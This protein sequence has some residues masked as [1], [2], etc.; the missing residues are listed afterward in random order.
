MHTFL[1]SDVSISVIS[2]TI[3]GFNDIHKLNASPFAEQILF[4]LTDEIAL[5]TLIHPKAQTGSSLAYHE[6]LMSIC[7]RFFL[8][9]LIFPNRDTRE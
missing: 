7:A 5:L 1:E 6:T 9:T 3:K 4:N 8:R 2:N